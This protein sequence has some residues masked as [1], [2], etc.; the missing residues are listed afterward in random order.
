ML[1][2]LNWARQ[3]QKVFQ[4]RTGDTALYR[5]REIFNWVCLSNYRDACRGAKWSA[6]GAEPAAGPRAAPAPHSL[7]PAQLFNHEV[8]D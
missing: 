8:N 3:Q 7:A 2:E 5:G 6:T 4:R 1:Q